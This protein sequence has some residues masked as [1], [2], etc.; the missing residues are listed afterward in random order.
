MENFSKQLIK[1]CV[2]KKL[3]ISIAESC[4][5]GMISSKLIS[6]PGASKV[7]DCGIVSYSNISKKIYLNVPE[8][9]I[10][11]YGAV[12]KQVAELMI[13]GLKDKNNSDIYISTTG[14]AGPEGGTK[15]KPVGTVFHS[16]SINNKKNITI[17]NIYDGSRHSIRLKASI[18]FQLRKLIEY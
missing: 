15:K 16:F 5:G 12:S 8:S 10:K 3:S 2:N 1:Y 17:K 18:F 11:K 7:L 14:I 6:V 4:T 13:D 9:E